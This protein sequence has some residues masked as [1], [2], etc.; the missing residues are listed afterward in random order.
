[1]K[2]AEYVKFI[3]DAFSVE[4]EKTFADSPDIS[5]FRHKEN[6][7]WFAVAM[8]V[9][10]NRLGIYGDKPVDIVNLKCDPLLS[11]SLFS[12]G[13]IFPAYHMNKEKWISVLLDDS[14]EDDKL[15]WLTSISFELTSS[16]IKK[17]KKND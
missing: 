2:R 15:K 1:M 5:V 9:P 3:L 17:R 7:K 12:E 6:R 8:T 10:R 13:G 4:E 16:K 14:V 11:G